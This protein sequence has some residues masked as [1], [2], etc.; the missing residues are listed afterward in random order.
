L[1]IPNGMNFGGFGSEIEHPMFSTSVGLLIEQKNIPNT[2]SESPKQEMI[3]EVIQP[4]ESNDKNEKQSFI[5]K[6]FN[7]FDEL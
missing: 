4:S 5:K 3:P 2:K 6:F 7:F 1:G